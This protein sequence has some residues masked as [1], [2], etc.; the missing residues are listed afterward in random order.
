VS[1]NNSKTEASMFITIKYGRR[2]VWGE[3]VSAEAHTVA[4]EAYEEA[5]DRGI[6]ALFSDASV[7][8]LSEGHDSYAHVELDGDD[9]T[10]SRNVARV[11]DRAFE[12]GCRA[13]RRVEGAWG[14]R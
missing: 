10:E 3:A 13:T 6:R 5:L 12:A 14:S 7:R 2:I 8:I 1:K 9:I 11:C 4:L